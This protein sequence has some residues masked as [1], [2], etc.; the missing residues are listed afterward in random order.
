MELSHSRKNSFWKRLEK[1]DKSALP[2]RWEDED[3]GLL[4]PFFADLKGCMSCTSGA[5][6]FHFTGYTHGKFQLGCFNRRCYDQKAEDGADEYREKLEAHKRGL[7]REDRET[8]QRLE[9]GLQSVDGPAL[10]ALAVTLVAQT[11]RVQLQHPFGAFAAGWSYE[12]GATSR[13]LEI[14]GVT[15]RHA[16]R[17]DY[18]LDGDSVKALE[19]VA[20]GDLRELVANLPHPPPA[21]GGQAG[22]GFPGNRRCRRYRAVR[23][24][25]GAPLGQAGKRPMGAGRQ[26][27]AAASSLRR[28]LWP[29]GRYM[30]LATA[31]RAGG[32]F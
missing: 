27:G 32:S 20:D 7:F 22:R 8:A 21:A 17:G 31:S 1:A 25:G 16:T 26:G 2:G 3:G 29:N 24:K 13:V 19:S 14:L 11:V 12:A 6:Y 28:P 4:P 10:R 5:A 30:R 18:F 9:R 15:L 23:L